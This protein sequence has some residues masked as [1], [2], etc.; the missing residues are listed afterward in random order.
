[1][2]LLSVATDPELKWLTL[3][4]RIRWAAVLVLLLGSLLTL[5]LPRAAVEDQCHA[6]LKGL[7]FL[8][9]KLGPGSAG[10]TGSAGRT[11]G[12]S[13]PS[14]GLELL[15]PKGKASPGKSN[16]QPLPGHLPHAIMVTNPRC[17][18]AN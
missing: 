2:N 4:A 1:M 12:L 5:L 10:V 9:G 13:V 18:A 11:T 7:S 16:P 17:P 3:W 6:V 8:R 14:S 15:V